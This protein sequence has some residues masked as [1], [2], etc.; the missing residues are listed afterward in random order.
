L[1]AA[2]LF[3]AAI[4]VLAAASTSRALPVINEIDPNQATV[5]D[6]QEFIELA[7][8]PL[9]S[10]NGYVVVLFNGATETS[11][12]SY[13]LDGY[14]VGATGFFLIGSPGM[15]PTPDIAFPVN[16]T[17]QNGADAVA[18]YAANG[19]DFPNGTGLTTMNLVDAIVYGNNN[20]VDNTLLMGLGQTTQYN[21][22]GPPTNNADI[23]SISRVPDATGGFQFATPSPM[24]SGIPQVPEPGSLLIAFQL[25]FAGL[26][27]GQRWKSIGDSTFRVRT[28]IWLAGGRA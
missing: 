8:T 13:D 2:N 17:L 26:L 6:A 28:P 9:S 11:Y 27:L 21:E 12:Q 14:T 5:V 24:N 16:N 7:G 15:T 1:G 19:S 3:R 20:A 25:A 22:A 4:I 10:L 23:V 18:F